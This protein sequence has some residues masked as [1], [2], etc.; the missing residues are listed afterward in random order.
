MTYKEFKKISTKMN[1][2]LFL[3]NEDFFK[4]IA[5]QKKEQNNGN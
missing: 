3:G 1:K 4:H 5:L 2:K